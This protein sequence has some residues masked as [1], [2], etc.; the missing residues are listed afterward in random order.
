[1]SR[2]LSPAALAGAAAGAFFSS[3]SWGF[4]SLLP[5]SASPSSSPSTPVVPAVATGHLALARAHPGLRELNA[6]LT[7]ASFFVDA[8]QALLSCALRV[9]PIHPAT[10]PYA[11]DFFTSQILFAESVGH[12]D[13][14]AAAANQAVN[15]R[16]QL[17]LLDARDG[18]FE[19]ALYAMARLA[20]EPTGNTASRLY[21]AALC[22]VLGRHQ[23][24]AGWLRY[25]AVPNISR[26]ENKVLFAEGVLTCALGSAPRAVAGSK[27]LVL[28]TTLGLVEMS[29]WSFFKFGDLPERL[30]VLALIAFLRGV[31]AR[32]LRSDDGSAPL[33]GS[34]DATPN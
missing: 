32:K 8:T 27:E 10:L 31:V 20:A 16:I 13:A 15:A 1:M 9:Q 2:F 29:M 25:A 14:G 11:R 19:D 3:V 23:D 33:E 5:L 17:A 4:S 12:A 24:G 21:A 30:Q 7:P 34:L 26:F 28:S 6:M 22:H 18:R